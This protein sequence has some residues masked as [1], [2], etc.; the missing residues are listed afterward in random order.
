MTNEMLGCPQT[1]VPHG[2]NAELG[3]KKQAVGGGGRTGGQRD[4]VIQSWLKP[5]PA[6]WALI[7][8]PGKTLT[9]N[10]PCGALFQLVGAQGGEGYLS[11]KAAHTSGT[12]LLGKLGCLEPPGLIPDRRR[13]D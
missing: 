4:R 11:P 2:R 5:A 10:C 6:P 7:I 8:C 13:V 12:S 3:V 1:G 9:T